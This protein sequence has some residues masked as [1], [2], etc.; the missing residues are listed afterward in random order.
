[1]LIAG[2]F[3]YALAV[4]ASCTVRMHSQGN[5]P[6][7]SVIKSWDISGRND[8]VVWKAGYGIQQWTGTFEE[9]PIL[10]SRLEDETVAVSFDG[11]CGWIDIFDEDV[12]PGG[13]MDRKWDPNLSETLIAAT[14]YSDN[15]MIEGGELKNDNCYWACLNRDNGCGAGYT[16]RCANMRSDL[17]NDVGGFR[18]SHRDTGK[19]AQ[20]QDANSKSTSNPWYKEIGGRSVG[21]IVMQSQPVVAFVIALGALMIFLMRALKKSQE[22]YV[23]IREEAV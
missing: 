6:K 11:D 9:Y 20:W 18:V 5:C 12:I 17:L 15:C 19:E 14:K 23:E 16:P 8:A 10:A 7:T 22:R 13:T 21:E 3:I 1:M 2:A 4:E